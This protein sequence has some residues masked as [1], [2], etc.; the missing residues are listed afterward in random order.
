MKK[1]LP[2]LKL[3]KNA[4]VL[5]ALTSLLSIGLIVALLHYNT[6][7]E[8]ALAETEAT[9]QTKQTETR[10]LTDNLNM[11]KN[12]Q[13]EF[14]HLITIGLVGNPNRANWVEQFETLY[15][16]LK[17]PLT[18]RYSLETPRPLSE[19]GSTPQG[20]QANVLRHEL[21]IELSDLHEEEFLSFVHKLNTSWNAPFRVNQ[22]DMTL[23]ST[24]KLEIKCALRLFSLQSKN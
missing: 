10:T 17:L 12:H 11:L 7:R 2:L 13:A 21:S 14:D 19:S 1:Y 4:L 16:D 20:S 22:C 24:T 3:A 8:E 5:F 6:A 15:R 18:L 23:N 9:V